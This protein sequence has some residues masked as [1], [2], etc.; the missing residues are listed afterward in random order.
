MVFCNRTL[1]MIRIEELSKVK[2]IER[3][4]KVKLG[5]TA[6]AL[7]AATVPIGTEAAALPTRLSTTSYVNWNFSTNYSDTS[8]SSLVQTFPGGYIQHRAG[9]GTG[10]T[11]R[12]YPFNGVLPSGIWGVKAHY[13]NHTGDIQGI[14]WWIGDKQCQNGTWRTEMFIHT[15]NPF[16][17]YLSNGCIKT[18][19]KE[20]ADFDYSWHA[21]NADPV[22][23]VFV[24]V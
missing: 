16:N 19:P 14:A 4:S 23:L 12:C 11:D 15:Q 18:N 2:P 6:V 5:L 10:S 20:I 8:N 7:G 22:S 3:T 9:S 24:D 17:N 21:H 13:E 1:S